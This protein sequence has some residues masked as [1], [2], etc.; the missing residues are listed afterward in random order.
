MRGGGLFLTGESGGLQET[1][2]HHVR[3][4]ETDRQT[5]GRTDIR[6]GI[7]ESKVKKRWGEKTDR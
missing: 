3:D 4:R 7:Q 1:H 6:G 5:D 2:S